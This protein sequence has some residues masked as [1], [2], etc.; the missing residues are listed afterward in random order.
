MVVIDPQYSRR[1][2]RHT[3]GVMGAITAQ[4]GADAHENKLQIPRVVRAKDASA[5]S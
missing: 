1:V 5:I 4:T 2:S 3:D